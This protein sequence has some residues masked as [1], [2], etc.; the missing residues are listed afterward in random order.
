MLNPAL[1]QRLKLVRQV[2]E[3]NGEAGPDETATRQIE[4]ED[5][6]CPLQ[7]GEVANEFIQSDQ[8]GDRIVWGICKQIVEHR[9][10]GR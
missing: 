2:S 4:Y 8:R 1:N 6:V 9:G 10:G 7:V 5:N 3:R